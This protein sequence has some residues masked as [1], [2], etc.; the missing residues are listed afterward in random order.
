MDNHVFFQCFDKH[1][2]HELNNI[3]VDILYNAVK[4]Y[5]DNFINNDNKDAV[6]F[7]VGSNAGSFLKVLNHFNIKDNIH[8]FEPHPVLQE[9]TKFVYPHVNMNN[10]CLGNMDGQ[11][12]IY[13]PQHSVGLS[14]V[15]NRPTF[16]SLNQEIYKI[17]VGCK[18][19]DTYCK[20]NNIDTIDFIKIDVEGSEKYV[21]EG[22]V[23]LLKN[24][25][26]K[27]GIFEI[28]QALYDANTNEDE[29]VN[30]LISYGYNIH[31]DISTN[32]YVFYLSY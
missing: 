14:S 16:S 11:I 26:I 4:F 18:K 22:A 1:N 2:F 20:E 7:D 23:E 13:I 8:C 24:N 30:M 25:K 17:N 29:I 21:F 10:Y 5:K 9:F 27:C 19:L 12:D 6:F 31:K 15:I 32:D 28:G 3:D